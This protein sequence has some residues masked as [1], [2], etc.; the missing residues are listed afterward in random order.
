MSKGWQP[1]MNHRHVSTLKEE[2]LYDGF[3]KLKRLRLCHRRFDG[4]QLTIERELFQ[5]DDAVAVLLYDP[6]LEQ[7]VLVEQ[8]RIGAIDHPHSPW[9]LEL[10]AGIVEPGEAADQVAHREAH[11]EA[12]AEIRQLE[13]LM[14]YLPS[15]GGSRE[16][17]ELFC[18]RVDSSGMGGLH[19]LADEHEDIRVHVLPT[20]AAFALVDNGRIDNAAT[21]IALQWLQ[22]HRET[23][24]QCWGV[25]S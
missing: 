24:K 4:D 2:M 6:D 21:I 23:L 22:L 19:G 8:F 15:P 10:V 17:V 18:G 9:L 13:P 5:R 20:E 3:F 7:V 11:E 12:G 16:Y 14:R 25:R 1:E